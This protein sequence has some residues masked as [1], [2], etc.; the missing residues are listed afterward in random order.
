MIV[1]KNKQ[2]TR[3]VVNKGDDVLG[4]PSKLGSS[5]T[6]SD[7]TTSSNTNNN[8][9]NIATE[10]EFRGNYLDSIIA[11]F[12]STFNGNSY[13]DSS[14][15]IYYKD[16]IPAQTDPKYF[17]AAL[18]VTDPKHITSF[19]DRLGSV[20]NERKIDTL[21]YEAINK[22]IKDNSKRTTNLIDNRQ[23]LITEYNLRIGDS[24]FIIPPEYIQVNDTSHTRIQTALRQDSSFKTKTGHTNRDV[25]IT[26]YFNG[27]EQINGNEIDSPFEYNYKMDGLLSLIAQF[28]C[29]PFLPIQN[30]YL[31]LN[32]NIFSVALQSMN[33]STVQ[34][35]P[36][37]LS[38]TLQ[39]QEFYST[40]Y[41]L[42]HNMTYDEMIDWD[43]FRFYYQRYINK[44]I[45]KVSSNDLNGDFTFSVLNKELLINNPKIDLKDDKNYYNILDNLTDN[46]SLVDMSFAMS[47]ILA[48]LQMQE[49]PMPTTQF[50]GGSD[51]Y[52]NMTF[53]TTDNSIVS[54]FNNVATVTQTM[55]REFTDFQG[56]GFIKIKNEI[57]KLLGINNFML[58]SLQINTVPEFP[59][60]SVINVEC[61]SYELGTAKDV[62]TGMR[63]FY[64]DTLGTIEDC[65][66]K[67]IYGVYNKAKQDNT[68]ERKLMD[69]ELYPDLYLPTYDEL[70]DAIER[71]IKYKSKY[72]LKP[73]PYTTY[74]RPLSYSPGTG[75]TGTYNG[76]ADP[77]FYFFY[78]STWSKS[79]YDKFKKATKDGG[80][81][82]TDKDGVEDYIVSGRTLSNELAKSGVFSESGDIISIPF[83]QS[84]TPATTIGRAFAIGESDEEY[85]K[86]WLKGNYKFDNSYVGG[87]SNQ[88][89]NSAAGELNVQGL[90]KLKNVT[91]NALCDLALSVKDV[92]W[93]VWGAEGQTI[94]KSLLNSLSKT[95]GS[96]RYRPVVWSKADKGL[97]GYDCAGL[98]RWCLKQLGVKSKSYHC[99][100]GPMYQ[101][102]DK[103]ITKAELKPGDLLWHSGHVAIYAGNGQTIEAMSS[104]KGVCIG[105]LG[106]RFNGFGR[107]NNVPT[108]QEV[109]AKLNGNN[110]F[111]NTNSNSSARY[112][113]LGP[114]ES[115]AT[116]NRSNRRTLR[117]DFI[118]VEKINAKAPVDAFGNTLTSTTTSAIST[119]TTQ[120][121]SNGV[122]NLNHPDASVDWGH[123]V[124]AEQLNAVLKNKLAGSGAYWVGYGNIYKINPGLCAAIAYH[125]TGNGSSSQINKYNNPGGLRSG[126]DAGSYTGSNGT[127]AKFSCL[128]EGIRTKVSLLSRN[129][130]GKGLVTLAQIGAK[131]APTSD[132]KDK[133]GLNNGWA[134]GVRS[135]YKKIFGREYDPS[136]SG[137]GVKSEML[138]PAS[139][140]WNGGSSST[141]NATGGW[142]GTFL[143]NLVMPREA[144]K[145]TPL[146]DAGV[147]FGR[148]ILPMYGTENDLESIVGSV[149]I[150]E[151]NKI[152]TSKTRIAPKTQ[153]APDDVDINATKPQD[154]DK[155]VHL[156]SDLKYFGR[157]IF[158]KSP[159]NIVMKDKLKD[160]LTDT[161]KHNIQKDLLSEEELQTLLDKMEKDK[162][163]RKYQDSS[164]NF[165]LNKINPR[166]Q[167][168]DNLS[169]GG[170]LSDNIM[171][172]FNSPINNINNTNTYS[173]MCSYGDTSSMTPS[174]MCVDMDTYSHNGRMT[175]AFPT[176]LFMI[177]DDGGDWVDAKKLWSNFYSYKP[178]IDIRLHQDY[179]NPVHTAA[180]TLSNVYS[181]LDDKE[182][183]NEKRKW[184][185]DV[186]GVV[187]WIYEKT[188]IMLAAPKIN[189]DAVDMKNNIY[190]TINLQEGCRIHLRMGY[191]SNPLGLP[192]CFNGSIAEIDNNSDSTFFV[193][194]SDGAELINGI[195]ATK[196]NTTNTLVKYGSEPSNVIGS[197]LVERENKWL[198]IIN[199]EWGE[200]S[201]H[202]IEHFGIHLGFDR[203]DAH[204]KEYDLL[205]NIYIGVYK[206]TRYCEGEWKNAFDSDW[207][208]GTV[209]NSATNSANNLYNVNHLPGNLTVDEQGNIVERKTTRTPEDG[210]ITDTIT[211]PSNPDYTPPTNSDEPETGTAND[212]IDDSTDEDNIN[213][214]LFNKTPWDAFKMFEQSTPEFI[215][216][217]GYHQF[218]SR[219][220]YGMP[221]FLFSYRYDLNGNSNDETKGTIYEA[222]KTYAQFHYIDGLD[223][224]I[225]NSIKASSKNLY[226]NCV[227]TY[228]LGGDLESTPVL[229]S[230]RAIYKEHQK[231]KVID[232]S[233]N[234]D[235]LGIDKLYETVGF[236]IGKNSAIHTGIS[237]LLDSWKKTYKGTLTIFGD[238]SIKPC[239]YIYINDNSSQMYGLCTV[240]E[241]IHEFSMSTGFTTVITPGLIG[242]TTLKNSGFNNV[243][244]SLI[245]LGS[246][247]AANYYLRSVGVKVMVN[248]IN[249]LSISKTAKNFLTTKLLPTGIKA[250]DLASVAKYYDDVIDIV[251]TGKALDNF[252]DIVAATQLLGNN[253]KKIKSVKQFKD[254]IKSLKLGATMAGSG[255]P[256]IGNIIGYV[257]SSIILD[258]IL[259][260]IIEEFM[261]NNCVNVYPLISK[262]KP[263]IA[264]AKGY[265]SLIPGCG[266]SSI[267]L[268]KD[269]VDEDPD[270]SKD[271]ETAKSESEQIEEYANTMNSKLKDKYTEL[272]SEE[273]GLLEIIKKLLKEAYK[274]TKN[275]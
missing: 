244:R 153:I 67:K 57:T 199:E 233:I 30:E 202:G 75:D 32:F 74:P 71:I 126:G 227:V 213:V 164:S 91:G 27:M 256:V 122:P 107:F 147:V 189:K 154:K 135:A 155:P 23:E 249:G 120:G 38:V 13:I 20:P 242:T 1:K 204:V 52:F 263:L 68:I 62:L 21:A 206:M 184:L 174:L 179:T 143:G 129:Y 183:I 209:F 215:C 270:F 44:K 208:T 254:C 6:P 139:G 64:K 65:I 267:D 186:N 166:L 260:A 117:N 149:N 113:D 239:D 207:T 169:E 156:V 243:T 54:M 211:N 66:Q 81:L 274:N 257:V 220:F 79:S 85:N 46:V 255:V 269:S 165:N 17:N 50:L 5:S 272:D 192:I 101:T 24:V 10:L 115:K 131:Y 180:I 201:K 236:A 193:A 78:S 2:T 182:S 63:P 104:D 167:A 241:A 224:V 161:S 121:Y 152:E 226:N 123:G 59:G 70:D 203:D 47:N 92:S 7:T 18:N 103:K 273:G 12:G 176:F 218:E 177:L 3:E 150:K 250:D 223:N 136:K 76:Y 235:Y 219:L 162:E 205:K 36:G 43:L 82:D 142:N 212:S 31:N 264:G 133:A 55:T 265:S 14:G 197:I 132:P 102:V 69:L 89:T 238:A 158:M 84:I 175:R 262:D 94:T 134:A 97:T 266:E 140:G 160:D 130:V 234:Q 93:Y 112:S 87:G 181:S 51:I 173:D 8:T 60:L 187:G 29:T 42:Q 19:M 116:Q 105:K 214:F 232:S 33:I 114:T 251:K 127:F 28:K 49:H 185:Q 128:Q 221:H 252:K 231:T 11:M 248:F 275:D 72:G 198:N 210:T 56:I 108:T 111:I 73:L 146:K 148:K 240:R 96:S 188:G 90:G 178:V 195:I 258:W 196:E 77:D 237:S 86:A 9:T 41:T 151:I 26:L 40:P 35:F 141:I 4:D 106:N 271:I 261:Y 109:L 45:N 253:L 144:P 80:K 83:S 157:P 58:N 171:G 118:T 39:M 145:R 247:F 228:S 98:I 125:E 53:E 124:T 216:Q 110:T 229:Y 170:T 163:N 48:N 172:G 200:R 22:T 246:S 194:Q 191:G 137:T 15:T 88:S 225:D 61:V 100:S 168:G 37:L 222:A 259:N 230:D 245:T 25:L 34:G 159:L 190:D 95:H 138:E 217:P 119:K 16:K 268:R 99:T